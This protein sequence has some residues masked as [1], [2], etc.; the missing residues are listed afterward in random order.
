MFFLFLDDTDEAYEADV[1]LPTF[2]DDK[3]PTDSGLELC[4]KV[5]F[6]N[7]MEDRLLLARDS[8]D[9]KVY[10]GVLMGEDDASVVLID[11]PEDGERI[12]SFSTF[13][14]GVLKDI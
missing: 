11:A 5:A 14:S 9:S 12:V 7:G 3:C 4:V 8:P 2:E 10:E 6:P 13:F 1:A